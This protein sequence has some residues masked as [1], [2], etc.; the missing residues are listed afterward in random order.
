MRHILAIDG[1]RVATWRV[2]TGG[3]TGGKAGGK[4]GGKTGGKPR[5]L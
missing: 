1:G 2:D 3:K 5:R 4:A